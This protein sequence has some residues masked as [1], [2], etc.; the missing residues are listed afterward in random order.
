MTDEVELETNL[1]L[2]SREPDSDLSD[3]VAEPFTYAGSG[4]DI[5]AA[6]RAIGLFSNQVRSTYGPEVISDLG[7]FGGLFSLAGYSMNEP[8]LVSSTDGVG[9]KIEVA[10]LTG[11]FDSIGIDLVAMCVDD[12]VVSG[13]R[14]L[15]FLDYILTGGVD[16]VRIGEVVSGIA[17]GCRTAQCALIGGEIADHGGTLAKGDL[18]LSGF[19]V[20]IVERS[21]IIDGSAVQVGDAVIGLSSPGLRSNGY[22]LARQVLLDHA[23]LDL[24]SYPFKGS[25][26][27]LAD[28]LLRP[29]VIYSCAIADVVSKL[30]VHSIAHVTGG[31]LVGNIPRSLPD[32][33]GVRLHPDSWAEP[34]I[35][36]LIRRLGRIQ[37]PEMR[38]VFNLGIG[39][40][41]TVAPS[42]ARSAL[43]LFAS[44]GLEAQAI[45]VIEE[46]RPDLFGDTRVRFA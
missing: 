37:D 30:P 34:A 26:T 31:G 11:R 1:E 6:D 19:A 39:M 23:G 7:G 41:V 43:D 22:T 3:S 20:G 38:R 27:S 21:Q 10:K 9:T 28:E 16:S 25:P 14:P 8:V 15:F 5:D 2:G 42:E 29:S 12:I 24:N 36:S 18:D 44:H 46:L 40:T 4:V 35:F 45:G 17:A 13:A 33:V 32:G